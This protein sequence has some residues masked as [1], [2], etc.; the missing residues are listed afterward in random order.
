MM[1]NLYIAGG[2]TNKKDLRILENIG[3]K[4]AIIG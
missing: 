3:F 1:K 2:V 4:G